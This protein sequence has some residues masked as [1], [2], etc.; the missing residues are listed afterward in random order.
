MIRRIKIVSLLFALLCI[1]LI[2]RLSYWQIVRGKALSREASSQ[3]E[4]SKV[5]FANR[6]DIK[7]SDGSYWAMGNEAWLVYANPQEIKEPPRSIALKLNQF[8][9]EDSE[10][11]LISFLEKKDLLWVPLKEK[12]SGEI[13]RGIEVLNIGGIGFE[14]QEMRFYPEASVAAQL[15]GFVGKDEAGE[16]TGYFGLEGYYNLSLAGKPGFVGREKDAA[17]API[18]LGGARQ[19]TAVSGVDLTTSLDKRIQLTIN[20]MLREGI[21][22][23]GAKAGTVIL[24]NPENGNVLGMESYP[25]YDPLKYWDYGD[26]YFKNPAI[27]DSFEPGSVFKVL[28]MA[29]ALDAEAVKPDTKCDICDGPLKVDKYLIET[30]NKEYRP[31]STMVDVLVHSDNV[32]MTFVGQKLGADALY[33]YLDKFGIGRPTGIDLQGENAPALR[34][35]GTWNVVDLATASFGQGVA[36]TSMQMVR[37]VSAIA[38]GGVLVTPRVVQKISGEGW[39][40]SGKVIPGK[41]VIEAG[42]AQEIT[43]MMVEAAKYGESQ[44]TNLRGFKIAGKTGTAQIPIAGHYDPEKTNA[45]FIGFA[46]YDKPKFVM[47]VTLKEPSTSPWASETAAP[48]WYLIAKDLF[49]YFGIQ[50]ED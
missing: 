45:S 40:E 14:V 36:V 31:D 50:P 12:V 38:N 23:Y 46:P 5:L 28:V 11:R 6:G 44:W 43:A 3:Y 34:K 26:T 2:A 35:K 17:G 18:L 29:A 32:G 41:K 7:A 24:M 8:F 42:T 27:S 47:L 19:V 10:E 20:R 15:L 25:S 48:L 1:C 22:R 13:K 16:D 9:K 39:E 37:A 4:S 49:P 33:D 30:W 21:E